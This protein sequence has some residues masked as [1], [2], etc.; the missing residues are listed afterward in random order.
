MKKLFYILLLSAI[1]TGLYLVWNV[2]MRE[3]EKKEYNTLRIANPVYIDWE[4]GNYQQITLGISQV[5]INFYGSPE[6]GEGDLVVCQ[7]SF[8][9]RDIVNWNINVEWAGGATTTQSTGANECDMFQFRVISGTTT[10]TIKYFGS[11]FSSRVY[12]PQIAPQTINT[13]EFKQNNEK[14]K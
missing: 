1:G 12:S 6:G 7:D 5:I 10:P 3:A 13:Y 11:V 14:G 4:D 9:G 8:G 2:A